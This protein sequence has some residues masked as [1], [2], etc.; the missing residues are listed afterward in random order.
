MRW[1]VFVVVVVV[2]F[3][4]WGGGVGLV[5]ESEKGEKF[6]VGTIINQHF[7]LFVCLSDGFFFQN[8]HAVLVL[9]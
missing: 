4:F 3:F 5:G 7:C 6:E 2:V 8:S 1:F 9:G